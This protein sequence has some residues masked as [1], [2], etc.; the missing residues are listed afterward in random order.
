[1]IARITREIHA[2]AVRAYERKAAPERVTAVAEPAAAEVLRRCGPDSDR[3]DLFL[4]PPVELGDRV[5]RNTA[6]LD[7]RRKTQRHDP[8]RLR[9]RPRQA[10]HRI[11]VEMVVV[12]VRLHHDI[13]RGQVVE[14]DPWRH[15]AA[16]AGKWNRR[17]ALAPHGVGENVETVELDEQA[18]VSNPCHRQPRERRAR[19]DERRLDAREHGSIGILGTWSSRA[20]HEHPLEEAAEPWYGVIDPRIAKAAAGAVMWRDGRRSHGAQYSRAVTRRLRRTVGSYVDDESVGQRAT[21]CNDAARSDNPGRDS[22]VAIAVHGECEHSG[23]E[24]LPRNKCVWILL[25]LR[26]HD[27]SFEW[28]RMVHLHRGR[29]QNENVSTECRERDV[30]RRLEAAVHGDVRIE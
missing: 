5:G 18:R 28:I 6:L 20:M 10:S 9:M 24:V 30:M 11:G 2:L 19:R 14:R 22:R 25:M 13:Q 12:V 8:R 7:E 17:C 23:I 21:G 27:D 16:R 29:T 4:A 15:P 3:P 26:V 1:M